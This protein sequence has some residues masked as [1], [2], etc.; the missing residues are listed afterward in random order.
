MN[1]DGYLAKQ[2]R[3]AH[4]QDGKEHQVIQDAVTYRLAESVE[5]NGADA[6]GHRDTSV[7]VWSASFSRKKSSREARTGVTESSR[8]RARRMAS[9]AASR[10]ACA[11]VA[12][13]VSPVAWISWLNASSAAD[14]P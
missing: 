9:M 13:T 11:M 4:H 5:R 6:A 8:P 2:E 10:S 7:G 3:G 1:A 12:R 14:A